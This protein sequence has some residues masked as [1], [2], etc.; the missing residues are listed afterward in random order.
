MGVVICFLV[1]I[2]PVICTKSGASFHKIFCGRNH[3]NFQIDNINEIRNV[4]FT[5]RAVLRLAARG[6]TYC[7][8]LCLQRAGCS[9]VFYH[10]Q[11]STCEIYI[12]YPRTLS[13]FDNQH[14]ECYGLVSIFLCWNIR[15]AIPTTNS[16]FRVIFNRNAITLLRTPYLFCVQ[17]Q[18]WGFLHI[19]YRSNHHFIFQASIGR[20]L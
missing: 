4:M 20:L 3:V 17:S 6:R 9:L 10:R 15:I 18:W 19:S 11:N 12:G 13:G 1:C 7:A 5:D 2:L 8:W 16:N 14:S